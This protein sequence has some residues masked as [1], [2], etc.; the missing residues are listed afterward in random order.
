[1]TWGDQGH[2]A[3]KKIEFFPQDPRTWSTEFPVWGCTQGSRAVLHKPGEESVGSGLADWISERE[4]EGWKVAWPLHDG[5]LEAMKKIMSER[6]TSLGPR[7]EKPKKADYAVAMGRAD[8][9]RALA[10]F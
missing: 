5:T 9:L 3:N 1:M 2:T 8:G 7:L 10:K 6:G 4:K